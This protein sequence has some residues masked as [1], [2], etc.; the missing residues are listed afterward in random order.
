MLLQTLLGIEPEMETVS[1]K[2]RIRTEFIRTEL[3]RRTCPSLT[4][5][6]DIYQRRAEL[7]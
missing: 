6:N 7:Q 4:R 2:V 3:S 5:D 1:R